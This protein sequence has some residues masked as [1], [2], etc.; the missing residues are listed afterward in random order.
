MSVEEIY[1]AV[2]RIMWS[3]MPERAVVFELFGKCYGGYSENE[4]WF[5]D[6]A[7]QRFQFEFGGSPVRPL[8]ELMKSMEALK[9][10]EPFVREPWTHFK[11]ILGSGGKFKLDF[12]Y[13]PK[14]EDVIGIYM[15]GREG[16]VPIQSRFCR[17]KKEVHKNRG[18]GSD[19][20]ELTSATCLT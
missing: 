8:Y 5:T 10:E 16:A 11:A 20:Q 15:R 14:E 9:G 17:G 2:A 6:S 7:G 3:I 18:S 19:F 12:A 4:V 13:I 1:S